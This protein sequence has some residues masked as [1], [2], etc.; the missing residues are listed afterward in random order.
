METSSKAVM[1]KRQTLVRMR[2]A[3]KVYNQNSVL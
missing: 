3:G 1:A 2:I